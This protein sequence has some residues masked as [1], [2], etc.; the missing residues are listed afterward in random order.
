MTCS[1]TL[2]Q[3]DGI[4]VRPLKYICLLVYSLLATICSFDA[5]MC[6]FLQDKNDKFD[7][8][9]QKGPTLSSGTGPS[10]DHT[11]GNGKIIFETVSKEVPLYC[12][13]YVVFRFVFFR[14]S[15]VVLVWMVF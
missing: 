4:K 2:R 15:A 12:C 10:S 8:T 7:W 13:C 5:S 6:G 1:L 9:R 3:S 14:F 11:S